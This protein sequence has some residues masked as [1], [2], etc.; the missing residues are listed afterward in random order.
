MTSRPLSASQGSLLSSYGL[1]FLGPNNPLVR[2]PPS[3]GRTRSATLPLAPRLL[4]CQQSEA[5]H[6]AS[7]ASIPYPRNAYSPPPGKRQQIALQPEEYIPFRLQD[8]EVLSHDTRMFRFALQ[9][10]KHVLG[11][12]IGQHVSMKFVDKDGRI[13]TR[14]YT[15]TSSD[16]NVGGFCVLR[17][18]LLR[19][20]CLLWCRAAEDCV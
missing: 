10:P 14:S 6:N 4:T 7:R 13:V 17:R 9:S 5:R 12:P 8:K 18:V 1:L 11:L 2:R 3:C 15:P 16:I 19:T 20:W